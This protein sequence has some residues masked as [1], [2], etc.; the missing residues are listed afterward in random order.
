[1]KTVY[2]K[3]LPIKLGQFLKYADVVQD[4]LEAKFL[5]LEGKIMVNDTVELRRGKQLHSGDLV[6]YQQEVLLVKGTR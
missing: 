6:A 4:G 5:I 2:V 3:N 1:M